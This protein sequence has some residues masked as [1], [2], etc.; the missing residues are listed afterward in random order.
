MALEEGLCT[1]KT[2]C[3]KLIGKGITSIQEL[4]RI[5]HDPTLREEEDDEDNE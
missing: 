4:D 3:I 5:V 1:L 2:S